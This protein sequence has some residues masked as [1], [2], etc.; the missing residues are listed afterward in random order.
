MV[1]VDFRR[2]TDAGLSPD[3]SAVLCC[4]VATPKIASARSED[5]EYCR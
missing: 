2:S 5:R 1:E 4:V 3:L